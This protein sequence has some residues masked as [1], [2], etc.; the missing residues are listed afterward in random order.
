M[1]FN[2]K[3]INK[4]FTLLELLVVI[5]IIGILVA[6]GTASYTT[7]QKKSRDARRQSDLKAIQN[8]MEQCYSL[9]TQYP[10]SI[11]GGSALGCAVSGETVMVEVPVDPRDSSLDYNFSSDGAIYSICADLE[12]DGFGTDDSDSD[13]DDFCVYNLQ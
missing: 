10:V 4:G 3:Y 7:A 6:I 5:A 13:T 2:R 11:T 9:D 12:A 8:A 1:N